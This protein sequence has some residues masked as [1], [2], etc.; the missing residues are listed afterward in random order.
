MQPPRLRKPEV[1]ILTCQPLM[2][3]A[4]QRNDKRS[5][6]NELMSIKAPKNTMCVACSLTPPEQER[7]MHTLSS[8]RRLAFSGGL[9]NALLVLLS[10]LTSLHASA[11]QTDTVALEPYVVT[12][13]RLKLRRDEIASSVTVLD[14]QDLRHN[15]FVS[16]ALQ[17]VRGI[18]V[19]SN[20][21]PGTAST[22]SLRGTGAT[23]TLILVNGIQLSNS[24]QASAALSLNSLRAEDI[25]RVEI[26][27]GP[28]STLYGSSAI[29]G[30]INIITKKGTEGKPQGVA[31]GYVGTD[32][33]G[34]G[35][36]SVSGTQGAL[37][38]RIFGSA[39]YTGGFSTRDESLDAAQEDD[40]FEQRVLSGN[41]QY[42][43]SDT[44]SFD[45]YLQYT[46]ETVE[47]D[48]AAPL[49]NDETDTEQLIAGISATHKAID[50]DLTLK[51]SLSITDTES[52][53]YGTS[54]NGF[55]GTSYNADLDSTYL[56]NNWLTL[57]GGLEYHQDN[58]KTIRNAPNFDKEQSSTGAYAQARF[59]WEERYFLT[60]GLRH[61]DSDDFGDETTWRI[62][63]SIEFPE[64]GTRVH[65]NYGSGYRAPTLGEQ[66]NTFG[67]FANANPN[68]TAETSEGF[69]I[70]IE[71]KLWNDRILTGITYFYN[72][73]SNQISYSLTASQFQ[74][75]SSV[76]T[77]GYEYF[78][79][80]AI[81]PELTL[82]ANYTWLDTLD[83]STGTDL[84]RQPNE[85]FSSNLSWEPLEQ[86]LNL[87]LGVL[88]V[89]S[90]FDRGNN[91]TPM[92][93]H[94][95]WNASAFYDLSETLEV[96]IRSENLFDKDYQQVNTFNSPGRQVYI[97]MRLT[98]E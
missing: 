49:N 22:V 50:D 26:I 54:T 55:L 19:R 45:T 95:L 5:S 36:L 23:Q 13:E 82:D 64:T 93:S 73:I 31:E 68:L 28:H 6:H 92:S 65:G 51:P 46:N 1:R 91:V 66:F 41:F 94:T 56:A 21:G 62:A 96:F 8:L 63:P 15:T 30:V 67:G 44:T 52:I 42:E 9:V 72:D 35:S 97:G 80:A 59:S 98:M 14:E 40:G 18:S 38:Y 3:T 33:T 77:Q 29:G 69:D 2:R 25:E 24:S 86:K 83:R 32:H 88:Y 78:I 84:G 81:L 39:Y 34:S 11:P 58:A 12:A 85:T 75:I 57:L 10:S 20:G 4:P 70:G 61:D 7:Y 27:R 71:Q 43:L 60:A 17:R 87:N 74:N 48:V 89:G 47:I 76:R 16:D 53:N 90:R 37:T 79:E